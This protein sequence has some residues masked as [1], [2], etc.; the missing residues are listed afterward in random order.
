MVEF[1]TVKKINCMQKPADVSADDK[2]CFERD[3]SLVH[4][5]S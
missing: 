3:I 1:S 4:Y 5:S 2:P